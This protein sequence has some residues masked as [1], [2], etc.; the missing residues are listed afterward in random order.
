MTGLYLQV[1]EDTLVWEEVDQYTWDN[2][3]FALDQEGKQRYSGNRVKKEGATFTVEAKD[4]VIRDMAVIMRFCGVRDNDAP[5]SV[6]G[7][8]IRRPEFV[9]F[10]KRGKS[11]L[12]QMHGDDYVCRKV[13]KVANQDNARDLLTRIFSDKGDVK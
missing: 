3:S 9:R 7:G 10:V 1:L 13:T 11:S 12:H 6:A 5:G 2:W 8:F 4:L